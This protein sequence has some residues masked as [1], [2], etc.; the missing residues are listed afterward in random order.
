LDVRDEMVQ[1]IAARLQPSLIASEV[2]LALRRPTEQLDAWGWMQRALGALL[3]LDM[4][5]ET[6]VRALDLLKRALAA[7]RSEVATDDALDG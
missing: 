4:R 5:R 2:N 1:A 3:H 7:C 6:L